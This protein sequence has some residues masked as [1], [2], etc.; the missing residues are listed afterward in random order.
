[1]TTI[2]ARG[3]GF[4]YPAQEK[5]ALD[6]IDLDF[7]QGEV[8]WVNGALGSGTSTLLVALAGLAPRLTGGE[9]RGS[10]VVGDADPAE[11]APLAAGIAYLGPSPAVQISGVA[12]RVRGEVALGPMNLGWDRERALAAAQ[13]ALAALDVTHLAERDPGA[14][15]GGETQRVLLAALLA[16][17][18]ATWLLDEPFSALDR[19]STE[20]VQRLLREWARAGATVIVAC[21]DADLMLPVADRVIVL[22]DGRVG[23]DGSPPLLLAGDAM[24]QLG[25]GTTDAA[26]LA[27]RAG[28]AAPRPLTSDALVE[29]I[30]ADPPRVTARDRVRNAQSQSPGGSAVLHFGDLSFAYQTGRPVLDRVGLEIHQGEAVG[31][32]GVNGAGKSTLLRLAMALEHPTSGTVAT[33]G[34][35]TTGLHPEDLAPRVAF[36]FQ[37]PERQLFAGS[38]RGEC[39]LA[40]KLAGCDPRQ[41]ADRVTGTLAELG[42]AD[43]AEQHPYDLPLP[44]RRLV[45]LAAILSADPDLLLLDEPT[46]AL[47]TASRNLVIDV[48]RRRISQ[49]K[50]VLAITHDPV[51]AHEALDRGVV[52]DGGRIVQNGEVRAVID[53][54]RL[55]RPAALMVAVS[56]GLGPGDDRRNEVAQLLRT[57]S[58]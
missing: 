41:A 21:D 34:K 22:R 46:A 38:V 23:L 47:D 9:R 56:L 30:A 50:T 11:V 31:L 48:I 1:M 15:S 58:R 55:A 32:F 12:N 43:T 6:S 8:T 37:S 29:Q 26:D 16:S 54:R 53:G 25:A 57:R 39:S 13:G 2:V 36:L 5:W 19:A 52:L 14:L 45:A 28:F 27:T 17:A 51:F 42:L 40:P 20:R 24:V 44:R 7:A 33:L 10:V 49:G 18:P 4:R 3:L 35:I